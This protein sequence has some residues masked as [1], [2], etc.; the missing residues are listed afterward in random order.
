LRPVMISTSQ[1]M[2]GL[3]GRRFACRQQ[4]GFVGFHDHREIGLFRDLV[5]YAVGGDLDDA[6]RKAPI[7]REI[8]SGHFDVCPVP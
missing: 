8:I 7:N 4:I 5:I 6:T 2:P 3:I 1:I